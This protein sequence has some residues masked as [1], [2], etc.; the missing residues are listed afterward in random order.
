MQT[1]IR[2]ER[3]VDTPHLFDTEAAGPLPETL[4]IHRSEL[5]DKHL[6]RLALHLNRRTKRRLASAARCRSDDHDRPRQELVGLHHD[7]VTN[8]VLL[9]AQTLR[10]KVGSCLGGW[11]I[12]RPCRV[13]HRCALDWERGR[14]L[15]VLDNVPDEFAELDG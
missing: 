14:E 13:L 10:V 9:M 12:E 6:R 8:P 5:L 11:R 3:L 7:S 4:H 1:E 2:R 15:S